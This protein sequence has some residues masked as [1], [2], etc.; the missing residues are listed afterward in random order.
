MPVLHAKVLDPS[1][2]APFP[3]RIQ[4]KSFAGERIGKLSGGILCTGRSS[5]R[6]PPQKRERPR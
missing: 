2:D 5:K 1:A 3:E 4:M 6:K